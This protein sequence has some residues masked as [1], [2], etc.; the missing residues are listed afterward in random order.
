MLGRGWRLFGC[1]FLAVFLLHCIN[2]V[3]VGQKAPEFSLSSLN[4]GAVNLHDL[5][6]KVVVLHFWA[7]WCPPCLEELPQLIRF[8]KGLTKNNVALLPVCVDSMD[9]EIIRK[10][11]AAWGFDMPVY[12]DPGGSLAHRYG[13]YRYPETY[14][15]DPKG[16]VKRKIVGPGDWDSPAW[17]R[18]LQNLHQK[19]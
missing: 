7:T 17:A 12:L 11:L 6:G 2:P 3:R 13:T 9:P 18:F 15:L 5:Q 1:L 19:S 10:F 8:H 16:V 4:G 14:I